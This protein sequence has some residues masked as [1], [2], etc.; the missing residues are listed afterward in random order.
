MVRILD[1]YEYARLYFAGVISSFNIRLSLIEAK[2][3]DYVDDFKHLDFQSLVLCLKLREIYKKGPL[4]I[5]LEEK[6]PKNF[7]IKYLMKV[8]AETFTH[9]DLKG[10]EQETTMYTVIAEYYLEKT[11][12]NFEELQKLFEEVQKSIGANAQK[13]TPKFFIAFV[14]FMERYLSSPSL[15]WKNKVMEVKYNHTI[16]TLILCILEQ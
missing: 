8:F 2:F 5:T 12:C 7:S 14:G 16:P 10:F 4:V 9:D 1:K 11:H 15:D 6:I 3:I 13:R